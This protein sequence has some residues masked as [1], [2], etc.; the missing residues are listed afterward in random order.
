MILGAAVG[1][2]VGA[3]MR[4]N[5]NDAD[6]DDDADYRDNG[7]LGGRGST[8]T[9]RAETPPGDRV[10]DTQSVNAN[11]FINMKVLPG[12][13]F[14]A[15]NFHVM[16]PFWE[17]TT[18]YRACLS[19]NSLI[20]NFQVAVRTVLSDLRNKVSF[21]AVTAS[22]SKLREDPRVAAIKLR[23]GSTP[24]KEVRLGEIKLTGLNADARQQ[25]QEGLQFGI[26]RIADIEKR[27]EKEIAGI[28]NFSKFQAPTCDSP[29]RPVLDITVSV[30]RPLPPQLQPL[31]DWSKTAMNAKLFREAVIQQKTIL[32]KMEAVH[33][34][35]KSLAKKRLEDLD[36]RVFAKDEDK[37]GL[38]KWLATQF[39]KTV[40]GD[41]PQCKTTHDELKAAWDN[42]TKSLEAVSAE[43]CPPLATSSEASSTVTATAECIAA[44]I[45]EL[46]KA[47]T[48]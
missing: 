21:P 16:N 3:A 13:L 2:R 28:L 18:S 7:P 42:I 29:A 31:F 43:R 23:A 12:P 1:L 39:H 15:R 48:N 17:A 36:T 30:E 44:K 35:L 41:C 26:E 34:E 20:N 27:D 45:D 37:M 4:L 38:K 14:F 8:P 24:R 9:L 19:G 5:E 47:L 11:D 33:V 25:I 22:L 40:S 6:D 32:N 46:L 10:I